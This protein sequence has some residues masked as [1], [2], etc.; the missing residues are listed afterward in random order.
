MNPEL[1]AEVDRYI[2]DLLAPQDD[3]LLATIESLDQ[4]EIAWRSPWSIVNL[5][6]LYRVV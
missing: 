4:A 6:D 3:A 2:A 5:I 1:V